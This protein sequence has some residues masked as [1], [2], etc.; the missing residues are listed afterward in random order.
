MGNVRTEA[1]W[2]VQE[3]HFLPRAAE[4]LRRGEVGEADDF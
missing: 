1:H 2:V 4:S 3:D